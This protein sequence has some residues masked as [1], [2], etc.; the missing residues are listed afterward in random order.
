MYK[1]Y[2]YEYL[3]CMYLNY[4]ESSPSPHL[5][6]VQHCETV[7]ANPASKDLKE[8]CASTVIP[9]KQNTQNVLNLL[10][11]DIALHPREDPI[12]R[13]SRSPLSFWHVASR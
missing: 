8:L 6:A 1:L 11:E 9:H 3:S 4:S 7:G 5:R 13:I 12:V 2:K 10:D